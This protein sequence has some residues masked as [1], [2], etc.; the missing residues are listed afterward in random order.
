MRETPLPATSATPATC[1]PW[2]FPVA[3]DKR[4]GFDGSE[5]V[6]LTLQLIAM[7]YQLRPGCSVFYTHLFQMKKLNCVV[8]LIVFQFM[9][10]FL[11]HN[12]IDQCLFGESKTF[13]YFCDSQTDR[14][15]SSEKSC[16][17]CLSRV[18]HLL[19]LV[20]WSVYKKELAVT[21]MKEVSSAK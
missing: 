5:K 20:A 19:H 1:T 11:F 12:F 17:N 21:T 15:D 14:S 16:S 18:F 6:Q 13:M 3:V 7:L 10:L 8:P 4:V 2:L 9:Q